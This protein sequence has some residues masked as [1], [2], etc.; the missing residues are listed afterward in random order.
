MAHGPPLLVAASEPQPTP[1]PLASA[2]NLQ[3][4]SPPARAVEALAFSVHPHW[5][6]AAVAARI[7][8]AAAAPACSCG[9]STAER[10]WLAP[11]PFTA[12][13]VQTLWPIAQRC[14][15]QSISWRTRI[16]VHPAHCMLL[17][18]T[19]HCCMCHCH[20]QRPV[21]VENASLLAIA[22]LSVSPAS[23]LR[24]RNSPWLPLALV[25]CSFPGFID[26]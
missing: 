14:Q 11:S 6:M 5:P 26:P 10:F 7:L 20:S 8:R 22:A 13:D 18:S 2:P 12:V 1:P 16:H 3:L 17:F 23:I 4:A 15:S 21:L 25:W 19:P 24:T 9:D